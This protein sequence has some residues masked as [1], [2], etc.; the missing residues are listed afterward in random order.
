MLK[1]KM[2]TEYRTQRKRH[3]IKIELIAT[4]K[5]FRESTSYS[6]AGP[7]RK[8]DFTRNTQGNKKYVCCKRK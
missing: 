8:P 6:A 3:Q 5:F 7:G 4:D 2:T 1:V